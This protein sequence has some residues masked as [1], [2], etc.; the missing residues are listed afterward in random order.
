MV[1]VVQEPPKHQVTCYNCKAVLAYSFHDIKES[2]ETDYSGCGELVS[3]ITCPC[4][5]SKPIV[6]RR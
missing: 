5:G 3:R 4:C 1:T 6:T 2:R